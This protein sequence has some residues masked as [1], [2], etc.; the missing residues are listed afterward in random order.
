LPC[1]IAS[2]AVA[3]NGSRIRNR[4]KRF[5]RYVQ[6]LHGRNY[7]LIKDLSRLTGKSDRFTVKDLQKMIIK[8]M[9]PQGH[10][11]N[12]KTCFM[13]NNESYQQYLLLQ[14]NMR[15]KDMEEKSKKNKHMTNDDPV[16]KDQNKKNEPVA[17]MIR[18]AIEEGRS[19][20][21]RIKDANIAIPGEEIS[22]KLDRLEEVIRKIFDYIETH[23]KKFPEI[24]KFTG[25]FL[26]TTLKLVDA[27]WEM[28]GQSVTGKNILSAKADI[29]QTLDTINLAFENLLDGLFE[30]IAMDISTDI[31]VMETMFA[32]EGLTEK[33]KQ[34]LY[35][36]NG[37]SKI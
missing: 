24:K 20:V 10:V 28:D 12:K 31:S 7:C 27:Y 15:M 25:Y 33:N 26:P 6:Q 22:R 5:Q 32:Q 16:Q 29:E 1:F 9:F 17:P 8:G 37:G 23:P 18:K 2:I 13:L 11:D 21:Q 4:L 14:E 35:N 34:N 19:C 30:D 36:T 3:F